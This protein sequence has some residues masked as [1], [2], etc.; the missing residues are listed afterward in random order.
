MFLEQGFLKG[1]LN[2]SEFPLNDNRATLQSFNT[3]YMANIQ[4]LTTERFKNRL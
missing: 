1:I 2:I 3:Q 4:S